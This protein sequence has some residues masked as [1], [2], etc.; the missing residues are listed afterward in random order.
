[1]SKEAL[2]MKDD[3]ITGYNMKIFL[4]EKNNNTA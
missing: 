4:A 1:M 2:K 3:L